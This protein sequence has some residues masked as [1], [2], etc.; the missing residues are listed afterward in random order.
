MAGLTF[1]RRIGLIVLLT[2]TVAWIALLSLFY[3]FGNGD[4]DS[5]R[6]LPRQ[7]VH[8]VQAIEA[9]QPNERPIVL[10]TLNT[11][12]FQM[13]IEPGLHIAA[14]PTQRVTRITARALKRS[15]NAI[16]GRPFS[17]EFSKRNGEP[18]ALKRLSFVAPVDLLFRI[19]LKSNDTLVIEARSRAMMNPWGMPIGVFAGLLGTVI[20][21]IAL[22]VMHRETRPL[23]RLAAAVDRIDLAGEP[24]LLPEAKSSA[25]EIR[26][27]IEAFNRLQGRL[28]QLL[29]ARMAMLGGI[30]HDVRTFATRLRLR[31]EQMPEGAERDRAILDIADM[32]RLLDD[33]LLASRAGAGE[34]TQE[35]V[36][37]DQVVRE[38]VA[39]RR[40]EGRPVNL[41]SETNGASATVLGDRLALRRVVANLIDNALQYGRVAHVCLAADGTIVE[42]TVDDEGGGIPPD[43]RE[44]LF[45]PFVRMEGSRNRRT[46][47][48]GLGL[49]VVRNLVE[50]HAGAISVR[51]APTGGARFEVRLPV[52]RP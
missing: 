12:R 22:V 11:D 38:E 19:G 25:P 2:V 51:D 42:L 1:G 26:G 27:L 16:G 23:A 36:E 35:L 47:G 8:A 29:K 52:F 3:L 31:I 20:G 9:V 50:A 28:S 17:V 24:V 6:P 40:S 15:L 45:E 41:Q 7:L 44:A 37:L 49:A 48:A 18:R 13:R 5:A 43:K 30:S 14:T 10:K 32:I 4:P 46:G 21:L 33:A 39:D 34:L